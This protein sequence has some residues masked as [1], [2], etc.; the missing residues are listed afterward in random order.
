[1]SRTTLAGFGLVC[2]LLS[3]CALGFK[4][5]PAPQSAEDQFAWRLVTAQRQGTCL[6]IEGRLTGA[7][8]NLGSVTAQLE[9]LGPDGGCVECPF[10][11][12]RL[13]DFS[14]GD[15]GYQEIGPYV[16]L[17]ICDIDPA[18]EYKFRIVGHNALRS[19]P[20]VQSEVLITSPEDA[21]APAAPEAK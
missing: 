12:D 13:A 14:R 7:Y 17:R 10:S 6:I 2:V 21:E 3:A 1:M 8:K 16:R 20:A 19:L 9:K 18:L 15:V 11:P 4:G 5:W